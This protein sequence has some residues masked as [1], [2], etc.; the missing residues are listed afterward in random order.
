MSKLVFVP[1]WLNEKF[2]EAGQSV[3]SGLASKDVDLSILSKY[4]VVNYFKAQVEFFKYVYSYKINSVIE[5]E[6]L[7]PQIMWTKLPR[8]EDIAIYMNESY[9]TPIDFSQLLCEDSKIEDACYRVKL[10]DDNKI[11]YIIGGN[12]K[13]NSLDAM[14]PKMITLDRM[15]IIR[16]ILDKS[17]SGFRIL[18]EVTDR[19]SVFRENNFLTQLYVK[20]ICNV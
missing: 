14:P 15:E 16:D 8:S 1:E 12:V 11:A 13:Y 2:T 18:T 7:F 19:S 10:S 17:Y 9:L 6:Y 4:D 5:L 20:N 3:I